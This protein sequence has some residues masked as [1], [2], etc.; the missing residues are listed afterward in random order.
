MPGLQRLGRII[1]ESCDEAIDKAT[2]IKNLQ[3][4]ERARKFG[5]EA[6]R[7][8]I[9]TALTASPSARE[10]GFSELDRMRAESGC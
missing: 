8:T 6:S 2:R 9:S 7:A 1:E 5:A 10:D 4:P 3:D